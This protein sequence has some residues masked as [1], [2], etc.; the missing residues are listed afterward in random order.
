MSGNVY[1]AADWRC[2]ECGAT[3]PIEPGQD[4]RP[5]REAHECDWL[6]R[7]RVARDGP[8][9]ALDLIAQTAEHECVFVEEQE[10]SGRLILPPCVTCGLT[11]MDALAQLRGE[12]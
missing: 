12:R 10:P 11:A 3:V 9:F 8:A 2:P 6:A 7:R 1:W 4:T 5:I